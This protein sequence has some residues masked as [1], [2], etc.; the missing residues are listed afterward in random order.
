MTSSIIILSQDEYIKEACKSRLKFLFSSVYIVSTSSLQDIKNMKDEV[1]LLSDNIHIV[2]DNTFREEKLKSELNLLL[3]DNRFCSFY[4]LMSINNEDIVL[5]SQIV[6][7]LKANLSLVDKS[8]PV[9]N[10][11]Y[12]PHRSNLI[13][14]FA[15]TSVEKREQYISE[16]RSELQDELTIRLN[17]MSDYKWPLTT[18]CSPS[19]EAFDKKTPENGSF[20]KLMQTIDENGIDIINPLDYCIM[21]NLGFLNP[22][23]FDSGDEIFNY[24][25]DLLLDLLERI[26]K[27]TVTSQ[28]PLKALA[29]VQ[30]FRRSEAKM[31]AQKATKIVILLPSNNS[32]NLNLVNEEIG[33][34]KKS[35]NSDTEF[36]IEHI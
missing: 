7:Q 20:S 32:L 28:I 15:Y 9:S 33:S 18:F 19:L 1:I 17:L 4:P 11:I 12:S 21:D 22:G 36:I 2:Y 16:H 34:I 23:P 3:G 6:N 13:M 8:N 27:L 25:F 5:F 30:D 35:I 29:V 10:D 26:K 24:K 14:L 31:L